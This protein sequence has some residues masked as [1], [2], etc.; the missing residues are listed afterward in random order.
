MK[1]SSLLCAGLLACC[2]VI[3]QVYGSVLAD[4]TDYALECS[5]P[6]QGLKASIDV[7]CQHLDNAKCP[8]GVG[9]CFRDREA[10]KQL[11]G[12]L[13]RWTAGSTAEGAI[14]TLQQNGTSYHFLVDEDGN[15]LELVNPDKH[16]A[17]SAGKCTFRSF[18]G[19]TDF[20]QK[21]IQIGIVT[22]GYTYRED[23]AAKL[24]AEKTQYQIVHIDGAP[25][26]WTSWAQT[27]S[28]GLEQQNDLGF[29]EYTRVQLDK[30]AYLVKALEEKY[31]ISDY[32]VAFASDLYRTGYTFGDPGPLF[33][34]HFADFGLITSLRKLKLKSEEY[35]NLTESDCKEILVAYGYRFTKNEDLW[36][37]FNCRYYNAN[38]KNLTELSETTKLNIALLVAHCL[39]DKH[40]YDKYFVD[41][42]VQL[43]KTNKNLAAFCDAE[44]VDFKCIEGAPS[45]SS[46]SSSSN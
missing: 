30:A 44:G 37:A 29:V 27:E 25:R 12:I 28:F 22:P 1:S 2:S 26:D 14:D 43:A 32:N 36:R 45:S 31:N 3:G 16:V 20:N 15:I 23:I 10:G 21:T 19:I 9:V 11:E 24:R 7:H 18:S 41:N 6:Q 33:T 5:F 46:G 13:V 39:D 8:A 17:F 34:P 35:K 40:H 42:L 38:I 4:K